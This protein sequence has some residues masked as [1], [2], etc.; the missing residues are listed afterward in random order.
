MTKIISV[1]P[2]FMSLTLDYYIEPCAKAVPSHNLKHLSIL[3]TDTEVAGDTE[4]F[5]PSELEM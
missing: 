2:V 5:E 3:Y 1:W 4:G